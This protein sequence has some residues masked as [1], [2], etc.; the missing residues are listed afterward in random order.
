MDFEEIK[1]MATNG[2]S[3]IKPNPSRSKK[4]RSR[5][6]LYSVDHKKMTELSTDYADREIK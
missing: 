3:Y 6:L 4:H 5:K 2:V 1:N